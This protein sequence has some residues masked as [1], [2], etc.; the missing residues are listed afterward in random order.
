MKILDT[1]ILKGPNYWSNYHKKL[2]VVRVDLEHYENFPSNTLPKFTEKLKQL[3]PSLY[4]HACSLGTEG[5]F[6]KRLEK[7][8]WLGHVM[9][10]VALELQNLAGM[11]CGFGRTFGTKNEG[12][13]HVI[14]CYEVESAG[15]YAAQAARNIVDY[16]AQGKEYPDL[17]QDVAQLRKLYER[18]RPGPSTMA[19][20]KEAKRRDIPYARLDEGS[21]VLLGQGINQRRI[22]GTIASSTSSVA[23]DIAGNKALTKKLLS[24]SLI[25]VPEG[26]M[27]NHIAEM[28]NAIN[29][30]SYPLVI[31]PLNANHGRGVTI[32][33]LTKERAIVAF[34]L[35]KELSNEVV[36]EKYIQGFDYR[37]LLINF[38]VVAVA[39]RTPAFITGNGIDSIQLLIDKANADPRRGQEHENVLTSIKIE[40]NTLAILAEKKLTLQSILP[41]GK[42]FFLKDTANISSGGTAADVTD[43]VHPYNLALAERIAR[44]VDLDVC[45]I[46]IISKNISLPLNHPNGAVIEVNASPGLR[47]HLFP[48]QGEAHNVAVPFLERI[49]PFE[50]AGRIPIIAV[51]GTNGKTTVVRLIAHMF[52]SAKHFVGFTC[53]DGVYLNGM[54]MHSSKNP[55]TAA[56]LQDTAV[57][58]AVFECAREDI[59]HAGLGFDQCD[60]S[61]ITNI[62]EDHLGLENID[63]LE[64]LV[65]LKAV[66]AHSTDKSGYAVLNAD[67]DLVYSIKQTLGCQVALFSLKENARIR[68]HCHQGGIATYLKDNN[69]I[70]QQGNNRYALVDINCLPLSFQGRAS[71]MIKNILPAVLVAVIRELSF[72]QI[73]ISLE[74]FYPCFED[75]PGRLNI[76]EFENFQVMV[77]FA[78]NEDAYL[79]LKKFLKKTNYTK[80]I[81]IIAASGDRRAEDIRNLGCCVGQIFDEIIIRHNKDKR[82]RVNEEITE[83]LMEG[84]EKTKVVPVKVISEEFS[85]LRYAMVHALPGSLIYCSVENVFNAMDFI[86][87]EKR[88]CEREVVT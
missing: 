15:L 57:D 32:N 18:E 82:G 1:K 68:A 4:S 71:L 61:V 48:N 85:A 41:K 35:A 27:I 67:D 7:G 66:V 86:V 19:I 75:L 26:V 56:I 23:V 39:K 36:V 44:L 51:T 80:K 29:L 59:L 20:L 38:K 17:P 2:I 30:L 16:L 46:D 65:Q 69:I 64:D 47:M 14:F 88:R 12:I 42:I 11:N 60:I 45:G 62:K 54:L 10:H 13:Y 49:Y 55:S 83:L 28:D 77:D 3:L 74:E 53:T 6:F 78:Q 50:N 5:G 87:E 34:E 63:S 40:E 43:K 84:I 70:I 37:F 25:P 72:E 79:E 33:I 76:I 9:E 73:K 52:K 31:K 22:W 58:F 81:G 21:L 8:T 24:T